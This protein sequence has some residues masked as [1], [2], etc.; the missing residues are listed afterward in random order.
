MK[1]PLPPESVV[2]QG[3]ITTL[4]PGG[5]EGGHLEIKT[6][7]SLRPLIGGGLSYLHRFFFFNPLEPSGDPKADYDAK[8]RHVLDMSIFARVACPRGAYAL[9]LDMSRTLPFSR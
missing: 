1:F 2:V 8:N 7:Y 5:G 6:P 3:F 9:I 4:N